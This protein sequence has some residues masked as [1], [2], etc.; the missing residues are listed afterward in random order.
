MLENMGL[1]VIAERPYGLEFPGGRR[2]W[3]QDLE[4]LVQGT[5]V[6]KFDELWSAR[7]RARSRPSGPAAWTATASIS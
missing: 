5:A 1:K 6:A 4:L 3:I 2:A 7:S